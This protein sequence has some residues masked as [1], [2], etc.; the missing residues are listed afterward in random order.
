MTGECLPIVLFDKNN[1]RIAKILSHLPDIRHDTNNR[2]GDYLK[3][4]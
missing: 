2:A 1:M 3:Q 4:C